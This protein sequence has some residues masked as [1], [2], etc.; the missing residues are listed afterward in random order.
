MTSLKEHGFEDIKVI[1]RG[2][3]GKAHLVLSEKDQRYFIA[4]TIELTCLSKK[5]RETATQEV[6]LLRRLDHPNIVDYQDNFFMSDTLVIIMQYC[7]G[8]D[9]Q[10][11]IK[12]KNKE[13]Q[14][15]REV[16]IMN[17]FVQ[18]LQALQYIHHEKRI[19]HRDLKTSNLFLMQSKQVVK[20]GD[21]GISRVLEG[22]IEAA[23]TVVGT[24]YYMSPEVCENKP[25]TFKSDVWSLGCVLY[26]LCMLKHAFSADNLLGLVYKIVSDKYEPIPKMYSSNLNVLIQ[27]MLEKDAEKRPSVRELLADAYVHN[28]MNDYVR[29]RGQCATPSG[30][31]APKS[32]A[33]P[34]S[35]RGAPSGGSVTGTA[36]G[37]GPRG[38]SREL[39]P[40]DASSASRPPR[41]QPPRREE[42]TS[43]G[44]TSGRAPGAP[45]RAGAATVVRRAGMPATKET[46]KEAA[47]R[48]K[49]EAADREAQKLKDAAR[50]AEQNK[51]MARQM[52]ETQFQST[53][54]GPSAMSAA[55]KK[56][57]AS[58]SAAMAAAG[59]SASPGGTTMQGVRE[60]DE[61]SL[62][63][64]EFEDTPP[65]EVSEDEDYSDDYDEYEDDFASDDSEGGGS[66]IEEVLPPHLV[67]AGGDTRSREEQDFTRVMANYE[68]DISRTR[69]DGGDR[70]TSPTRR[71]PMAAAPSGSP[72]SAGGGG[73]KGGAIMDMKARQQRCR[74][75]LIA[76]MGADTFQTC[77]DYLSQARAKNMDDQKVKKE[78]EAL[79][80]RD[81]YKEFGFEVDQVVFSTILY[82]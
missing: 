22:S 31:G 51:L 34:R 37:G 27:R 9:L 2:Q 42:R 50:Q 33:A 18:V 74:E 67:A 65:E 4:K 8:G 60:E 72:A 55:A 62:S 21:F 79:V 25:Y 61:E 66:D 12:E 76:R 68:Q 36:S 58:N 1:G 15:I 77:F 7:E 16:Q 29:T 82:P 64:D 32:G 44:S 5:E 40:G 53:R 39:Q 54:L 56:V 23:I 14:R 45:S 71:S 49:R 81:V 41:P 80:G 52:K 13:K 70:G 48:R 57:A 43:P 28:F 24:P 3:Y 35:A 30:G 11:Y 19:L 38:S 73:A 78:L 6:E 20:L 69:N 63:Q 46:P 47:L 75:D 10:T 26:E 17:Y 59:G